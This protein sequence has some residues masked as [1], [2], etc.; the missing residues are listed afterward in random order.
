MSATLSSTKI[1]TIFFTKKPTD[2]LAQVVARKRRYI[3]YFE[4]G[5]A[6]GGSTASCLP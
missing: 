2:W 5:V 1:A 6:T 3:K 4:A